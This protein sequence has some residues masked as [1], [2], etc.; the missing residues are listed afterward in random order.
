[1][2][3]KEQTNFYL[4]KFDNIDHNDYLLIQNKSYFKCD[5]E[6]VG[7]EFWNTVIFST[8]AAI[9]GELQLVSSPYGLSKDLLEFIKKDFKRATWGWVLYFIIWGPLL[10]FIVFILPHSIAKYKNTKETTVI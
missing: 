5:E 1:L 7:C 10:I 8:Q 2:L 6:D 4:E 3:S 9:L